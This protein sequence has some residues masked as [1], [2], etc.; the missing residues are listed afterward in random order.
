[1]SD[2][3]TGTVTFL[4]T[5]IEG[6]TKLWERDPE[7]MSRALKRHDELATAIVEGH[8]GRVIRSKGEGDSLFAVFARASDAVA[9][10]AE[11]Q[12]A[13]HREPWREGAGL[14]VRMALRTGEAELRDGDFYGTAV[15]RCARIR[16]MAHGGQALASQATC[17]LTRDS[18][19]DGVS[20]K[21]VGVHRL[22]DLSRVRAGALR[23]AS[24][25]RRPPSR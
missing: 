12:R 8:D 4:L 3:P 13:F 25:C 2:L 6:S 19:P 11:L 21:D 10:T 22:K 1:M 15:N 18:L 7:P 9:A 14:R 24:R 5:D 23:R 16:A 20:L 17:E